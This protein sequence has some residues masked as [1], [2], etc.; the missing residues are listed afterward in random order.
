MLKKIAAVIIAAITTASSAACTAQEKLSE[1]Y[2]DTS[3]SQSAELKLS[4]PD[5][6][7]NAQ[8]LYSYICETYKHG[9]ISGQ[10]ESTWMGSEQYEFD[11]IYD[12][13]GKYPAIRG[14]VRRNGSKRA[15]SSPYAG[16]AA[17]ISATAG[18][19]V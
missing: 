13:T 3:V 10:Q 11:Y 18:T 5:A 14:L 15:A 2:P 9:I 6:D 12:K 19:N 8:A 7:K 16:T 4:N 1:K 17:R